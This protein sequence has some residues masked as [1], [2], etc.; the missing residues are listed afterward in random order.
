MTNESFNV[1]RNLQLAELILKF[2]K[3]NHKYASKNC[4][5]T[6]HIGLESFQ[7]CTEYV[8]AFTHIDIGHEPVTLVFKDNNNLAAKKLIKF[9][10]TSDQLDSEDL[11]CTLSA[12]SQVQKSLRLKFGLSFCEIFTGIKDTELFKSIGV[13]AL[14]IHRAKLLVEDFLLYTKDPFKALILFAYKAGQTSV[15]IN[16]NHPLVTWCV[17]VLQASKIEDLPDFPFTSVSKKQAQDFADCTGNTLIKELLAKEN[18][19]WKVT[20]KTETGL[21]KKL[22]Q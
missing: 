12:W 15:S 5:V 13:T 14:I 6:I 19:P 9:L 17:N 7:M 21:R 8:R 10:A 16:E 18:L 1:R 2:Y 11:I 4:P 20:V 3:Q 22:K